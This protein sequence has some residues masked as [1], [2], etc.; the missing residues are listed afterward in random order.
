MNK[1]QQKDEFDIKWRRW[2]RYWDLTIKYWEIG[3][4]LRQEFPERMSESAKKSAEIWLDSG[5]VKCKHER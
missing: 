4:T 2:N 3:D 5:L 1:V